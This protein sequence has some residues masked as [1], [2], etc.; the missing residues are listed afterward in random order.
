MVI[1]TSRERLAELCI[2]SGLTGLPRNQENRLVLLKSGALTLGPGARYT[3]SEVDD[4]LQSSLTNI[5]KSIQLDHVNLRRWLV[6]EKFL[7]RT[8][9]GS[10][11]WVGPNPTG[12]HLFDSSF[13][14]CD[15]HAVIQ[16]G[17]ALLEKRKAEY[18]ERTAAS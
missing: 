4:L 2:K 15:P 9:N 12:A 17:K 14:G 3:E 7:E 10:V 13:E 8:K 6:D 1:H 18:L 11:Y 5:G 16:S